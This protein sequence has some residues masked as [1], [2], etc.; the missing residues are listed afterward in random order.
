MAG[1]KGRAVSWV[2]SV[3]SVRGPVG[4]GGVRRLVEAV[5]DAAEVK[6]AAVPVGVVG[7]G[8]DGVEVV[9]VVA[10]GARVGHGWYDAIIEDLLGF[11]A[12]RA[13]RRLSAVW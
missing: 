9:V 1:V 3:V 10:G 12:E 13:R 4:G 11:R 6:A 8:G 5:E 2:G 7:L